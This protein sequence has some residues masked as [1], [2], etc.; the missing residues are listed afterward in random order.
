MSNPDLESKMFISVPERSVAD[1]GSL[2]RIL[3]FTHPGSRI[4]R[5]E[6]KKISHV[7][8]CNNKFHKIEHC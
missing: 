7:F 3:I 6:R 8:F 4:K 5:E 2:S 1:P